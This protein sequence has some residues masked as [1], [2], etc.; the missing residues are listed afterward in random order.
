VWNVS[1]NVILEKNLFNDEGTEFGYSVG[2]SRPIGTLASGTTCHFCAENFVVGVEAYGGLGS[3]EGTARYSGRLEA[4]I[5]VQACHRSAS[6]P[7][8][9]A[10]NWCCT[11]ARWRSRPVLSLQVRPTTTAIRPK[12]WRPAIRRRGIPVWARRIPR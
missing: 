1:E 10:G 5:P 11:S 2:V 3:T 12:S 6:S 7:T 9:S 4:G 8:C